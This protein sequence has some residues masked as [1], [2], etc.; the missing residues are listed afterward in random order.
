MRS[1]VPVPDI[2]AVARY[3]GGGGCGV[4]LVELQITPPARLVVHHSP[5]TR[6]E[7]FAWSPALPMNLDI[8]F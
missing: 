6:S 5:C 4:K 1:G 8:I 7:L 3:L 2:S